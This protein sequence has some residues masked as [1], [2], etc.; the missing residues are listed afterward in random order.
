M[1]PGPD[2]LGPVPLYPPALDRGAF[3][4]LAPPMEGTGGAADAE[5][6]PKPGDEASDERA[7]CEGGVWVP[8]ALADVEVVVVVVVG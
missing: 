3:T 2:A 6:A 7:V 8:V 5:L 1:Y 4:W